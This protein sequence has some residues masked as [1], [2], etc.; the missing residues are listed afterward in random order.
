[1]K[2]IKFVIDKAIDHIL[3]PLPSS[4]FIPKWYRSGEMY[5]NKETGLREDSDG[6]MSAAGMR[7]CM[8]FFDAIASG[9]MLTAWTDIE[10]TK[11]SDG[12]IEFQYIEKNDNGDW[13]KNSDTPEIIGIR[14]GDIGS[15]IPRPEGF[16]QAH[17]VWQGKWGFE[18]PR[19]WSMLITHPLNQYDFPFFT[20]SGIIDSDTFSPSGNLPFFIKD[21]WTGIIYK[22]T[23]IAQLIPIKRSEWIASIEHFGGRHGFLAN[24]VRSEKSGVY[25]KR[26]WTPKKYKIKD[27]K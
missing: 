2:S 27:K 20:L 7:S 23:P 15:T 17:L 21:G 14:T 5:V 26:M 12:D 18:L 19:G 25:K 24:L 3:P 22:G 4:K 1:M 10:I 8:P 16:S 13:I 6:E 11:N 9:Y